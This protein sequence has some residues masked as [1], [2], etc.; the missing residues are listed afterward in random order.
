VNNNPPLDDLRLFCAIVKKL[1]FSAAAEELGISRALVS[2]RIALLEETLGTR[3]LNRTTRRVSVTEQGA[4]VA[5][6]A[7]RIDED[8]EQMSDA[9]SQARTSPRGHLRVCSSTGFGRNRLAPA[10]SAL[11]VQHPGLEIALELLDRPVDLAGEGFDVDIRVGEIDAPD[12]IARKIASNSR[13]LCA[14][15]RYLAQFGE[16]TTLSELASHRCLPVRERDQAFGRWK[17]SGPDG[18]QVVRVA[19]PMSSNNGEVVHAWA[20]D[21]HGIIL[22]SMWDV[23]PSLESGQLVRVLVDYAQPADVWA[24]YQ[25]GL[26]ASAKMRVFV[27]FLEHWFCPDLGSAACA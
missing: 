19:G 17:L 26:S 8:L 14:A 21:G 1:S 7:Q 5:Q 24:L 18:T 16:P 27:D 15:P 2:K 22:R 3:L 4:I 20:I 12:L 9:L 23:K 10:I 25:N 6:W 11:A 13:V